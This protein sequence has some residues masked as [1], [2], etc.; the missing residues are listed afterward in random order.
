MLDKVSSIVE[1]YN[2]DKGLIVSIL[3]DVQEEFRY[4]PKEALQQVSTELD[5][6]LSQVYA[7]GTF[8]KT[9]S[10]E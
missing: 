3:Q 1:K 2:R 9:F 5:V 6:P 7:V 10:L 8:Y 4:L